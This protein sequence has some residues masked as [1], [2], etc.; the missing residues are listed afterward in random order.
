[1]K[2]SFGAN[3]DMD[4]GQPTCR[5]REPESGQN[6]GRECGFGGEE[7]GVGL[8]GSCLCLVRIP[9]RGAGTRLCEMRQFSMELSS[10]DYYSLGTS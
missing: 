6:Q 8:L 10:N 7:L 2:V 3:L 1:M 4:I 9:F 5:F